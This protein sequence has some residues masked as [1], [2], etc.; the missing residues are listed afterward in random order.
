MKVNK[1][2][3]FLVKANRI[4]GG[5]WS[6]S[7]PKTVAVRTVKDTKANGK[8]YS[9]A[10]VKAFEGDKEATI[11]YGNGLYNEF[12]NIIVKDVYKRQDKSKNVGEVYYALDENEDGTPDKY[13]V[14]VT[15]GAVNGL[16][17][18]HI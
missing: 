13:Q 10:E 15:F 7:D 17:L 4:Y 12:F 9:V 6:A 3:S 18:I 14:T 2:E 16:S 1:G 11:W 5:K 8:L